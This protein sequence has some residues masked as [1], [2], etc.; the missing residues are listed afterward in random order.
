[1]RIT[2][3]TIQA[4]EEKGIKVSFHPESDEE[5]RKKVWEKLY[6]NFL[7]YYD[8]GEVFMDGRVV[9]FDAKGEYEQSK[10]REDADRKTP[11]KMNDWYNA[12][13][14]Y[15]WYG[16]K[17]RMVVQKVSI[18]SKEITEDYVLKLIEKNEKSYKGIYGNFAD[19]MNK[20]IAGRASQLS[21]YPTTYGIGIW[22]FYNFKAEENITYVENILKEKGIE[23]YNEYS[24]ARYVYRFKISKKKENLE[25]I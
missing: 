23:Y 15:I 11:Y 18:K 6:H 4:I 3:Q 19:K 8:G 2:Q 24:D 12:D 25:R 5:Y 9:H 21:I 14:L 13:T 1:M 22:I 17:G 16:D 10:A 20:L 7:N